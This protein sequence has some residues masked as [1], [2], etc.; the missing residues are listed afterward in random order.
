MSPPP[1]KPDD[2]RIE[3]F[4]SWDAARAIRD[5][6]DTLAAATHADI[7]T[8]FDAAEIWWRHYAKGKL[9]IL[10]ARAPDNS[11][12]GAIP[13]TIESLGIGPFRI[14]LARIVGS[15]ATIVVLR[16]AVLPEFRSAFYTRVISEFLHTRRCDAIAFSAIGGDTDHADHIRRAVSQSAQPIPY[17]TNDT[18][19]V[20]SL[21]AP[22]DDWL[23]TLSKNARQNYRAGMNRLRRA[24]RVEE[25]SITDPD[26]VA[27]AF[28]NF[29]NIHAHQWQGVGLAGHFI[30]WPRS[31]DFARD[32]N[33]RFAQTNRALLTELRIDDDYAAGEWC[34]KDTTRGYFRL[35]A[36]RIGEPWDSMSIGRLSIVGMAHA[37]IDHGLTEIEGGPGGFHYKVAHGAVEH[38]LHSIIAARPTLTSRVKARALCLAARLIDLAYFKVWRIRLARRLGPVNRPLWTPWI[39]TRL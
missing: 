38:P 13:F 20:F 17:H 34:F 4:D 24:H 31:A 22:F 35:P 19:T 10:A 9:A 3:T 16:P 29:I 32:L 7:Y 12:I 39:R 1:C 25:H 26:A 28:E 2:L 5:E 23:A 18:H 14:R 27:K 8:T 15:Y 6:W 21:K 11:L 33:A 36:R 30:D 37:M